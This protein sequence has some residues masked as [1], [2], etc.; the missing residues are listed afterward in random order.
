MTSTGYFALD[1]AHLPLLTV[2]AVVDLAA[3]LHEHAYDADPNKDPGGVQRRT[4]P[5]ETGDVKVV[6]DGQPAFS[7]PGARSETIV[8]RRAS[9]ICTRQSR[10]AVRHFRDNGC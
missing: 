4:S 7:P 5:G 1:R 6:V 3:A 9:G 10:D 8:S 2:E